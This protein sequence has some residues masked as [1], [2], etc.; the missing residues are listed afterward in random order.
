[1]RISTPA[2][3]CAPPLFMPENFFTPCAPA[4]IASSKIETSVAPLSSTSRMPSSPK[5]S[6][7]PCVASTASSRPYSKPFGN[8]GLLWIQGSIAKRAPPGDSIKNAA[9]PSQVIRPPNPSSTNRE[10][11]PVDA[12]REDP[13]ELLEPEAI[14]AVEAMRLGRVDVEDADQNAAEEDRNDDLGSRRRV[15]RDVARKGVD[16]GHDECLAPRRGRAADA[17]AE[18]DAH[19]GRLALEGSEDELALAQQVE[20]AP[21]DAL[22]RAGEEARRVGEVRERVGLALEE[23]PERR[24]E[25][26]VE[27]RFGEA[28]V[29]RRFEHA[30]I[31]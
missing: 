4:C 24:G 10:L 6:K 28:A 13:D 15:A 17:P 3:V 12:R 19:A 2:T 27:R 8:F 30:R 16:V 23:R 11:L 14:L 31:L 29:D 18:R 5:W 22:E 7:W 9:W 20:A 1:M 26:G 25:L 21:V